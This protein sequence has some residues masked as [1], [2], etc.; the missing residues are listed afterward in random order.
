ME[1]TT[2]AATNPDRRQTGHKRSAEGAP[3]GAPSVRVF[4]AQGF[5][6]LEVLVAFVIAALALAVLFHAGVGGL[7]AV[8]VAS[9]E[10]QAVARAR[11]HLAEAVH[12]SPLVAGDWHGD[13]GGGFTWHLRVVP[14]ASAAVQ[15]VYSPTPM[16]A[17]SV[18]VTLY[19]LTVWIGWSDSGARE[20]RLETE[21]IGAAG[22]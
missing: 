13:D 14:V 1:V 2:T 3:Q 6:L 15:P 19:D 4:A 11:S 9:H 8:Q 12:A 21:Q 18:P 5:T 20:V 17:A 22:R 16:R 7:Q 10:E